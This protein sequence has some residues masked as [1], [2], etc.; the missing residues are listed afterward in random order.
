MQIII[1]F[2]KNLMGIFATMKFPLDYID[3]ILVAVL[4]YYVMKFARDTRTGHLIKGV[5]VIWVLNQLAYFCELSALNYILENVIQ[6]SFIAIIIVFQPELRSALEKLGRV[7]FSTIRNIQSLSKSDLNELSHA[8]I[9]SVCDSCKVLSERRIGALIVFEMSSKL[10]EILDTG[11]NIDA[12]VTP[13]TII[14]MFF[15]NTPLHDGAMIIR[16]NRIISAG[17]LL[18]LSKNLEISKELG[19]RHRA[20]VGITEN[21]DALSVIVSEE[22][23]RISYAI[24]GKIN[25]DITIE[26][27]R[28]L[29]EDKF[30]IP[31]N[32]KGLFKFFN[33]EV[34]SDDEN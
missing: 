18:P 1:D 4:V 29:L 3:I 8:M 13:Q 31:E 20:A 25:I 7:K 10:G 5:L 30:I 34:T 2:F 17:C 11:I 16:D 24:D 28:T 12:T 22:T 33:K 19:T 32:K 26:Q 6:L 9:D 14:T 27:L 23:G 21:S 15:P